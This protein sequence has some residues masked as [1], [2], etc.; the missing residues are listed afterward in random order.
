MQKLRKI[1]LS[2]VFRQKISYNT[3]YTFYAPSA[4]ILIGQVAEGL[5]PGFSFSPHTLFVSSSL[6]KIFLHAASRGPSLFCTMSQ[7]MGVLIPKYS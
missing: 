2:Q 4:P 1:S 3:G 5:G 6:F 7:T